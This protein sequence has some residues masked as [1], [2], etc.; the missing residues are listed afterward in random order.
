MPWKGRFCLMH[1]LKYDLHRPRSGITECIL[2]LRQK[3]ERIYCMSRCT[4]FIH[5]SQEVFSGPTSL[6]FSTLC[7]VSMMSNCHCFTCCTAV[8][9]SC[10]TVQHTVSKGSNCMYSVEIRATSF[11]MQSISIHSLSYQGL[12]EKINA[13]HGHVKFEATGLSVFYY[14]HCLG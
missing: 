8:T 13:T 11:Y 7:R 2:N 12:D 9:P 6:S 5:S 3:V 1:I 14:Y 10:N 4:D